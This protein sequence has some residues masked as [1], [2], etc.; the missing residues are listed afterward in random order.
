MTGETGTRV[1]LGAAG[2]AAAAFGILR[3]LQHPGMSHPLGLARWLIGALLVHD[4]VIAPVVLGVGWLLTRFV[5]PRARRFVQAALVT[6]GLVSA[7]GVLLIWRQGTA[8]ATSLTL[9]DQNYAANL[10]ALLILIAGVTA[11]AYLI[12]RLRSSRTNERPPRTK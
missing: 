6:G 5:P 12:A 3:I 7:L 1:V 8:S 9:L 4:V 2:A 10:A 11:A